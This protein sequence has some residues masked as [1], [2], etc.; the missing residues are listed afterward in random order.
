MQTYQTLLIGNDSFRIL[1]YH[2]NTKI[3]IL[4]YNTNVINIVIVGTD[5]PVKSTQAQTLK[6]FTKDKF[7]THL[8]MH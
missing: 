3:L 1:L 8:F 4:Y 5:C 2:R 6:S 7:T